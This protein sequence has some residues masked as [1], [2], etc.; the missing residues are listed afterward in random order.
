M[1]N[2]FLLVGATDR[3]KIRSDHHWF[4]VSLYSLSIFAN[5]PFKEIY[6]HPCFT[7]IPF[8]PSSEQLYGRYCIYSSIKRVEF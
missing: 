5:T 2:L 3:C 4:D 6:L 8:W 7:T 1:F